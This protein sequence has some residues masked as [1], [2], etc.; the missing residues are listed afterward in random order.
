MRVE[1]LEVGDGERDIVKADIAKLDV[2]KR[3]RLAKGD[4][5]KLRSRFAIP[6]VVAVVIPIPK[7]WRLPGTAILSKVYKEVGISVILFLVATIVFRDGRRVARAVVVARGVVMYAT[8]YSVL[9]GTLL[10]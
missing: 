3:A 8:S 6:R 10:R 4:M 1:R 2:I 7:R 9:S 5:R